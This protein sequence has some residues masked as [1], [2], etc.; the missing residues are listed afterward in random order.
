[1]HS[2]ISLYAK[3]LGV[4]ESYVSPSNDYIFT[5]DLQ[6]LTGAIY[7]K[8]VFSFKLAY[9]KMVEMHANCNLPI[10]LDSPSGREIDET[11]IS[12]IIKILNR[13][14]SNH[15]IIIASIFKYDIPDTNTIELKDKLLGF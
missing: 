1:M 8:I 3:E 5:S 9:V 6:S 2:I 11:N 10:I 4:D 15:Q 7:H 14:F 13:D 12:E